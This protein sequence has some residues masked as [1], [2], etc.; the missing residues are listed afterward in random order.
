MF[1]V[2]VLPTEINATYRPDH[3]QV[4]TRGLQP[5]AAGCSVIWPRGSTQPIS[6]RS[7]PPESS[8]Y[9]TAGLLQT[10]NSCGWRL[11]GGFSAW[12]AWFMVATT[13]HSPTGSETRCTEFRCSRAATARPAV[14]RRPSGAAA[15]CPVGYLRGGGAARIA[16]VTLADRARPGGAL[17]RRGCRRACRSHDGRMAMPS[18][19]RAGAG[20]PGYAGPPAEPARVLGSDTFSDGVSIAAP[21]FRRPRRLPESRLVGTDRR[22]RCRPRWPGGRCHRR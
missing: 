14:A 11:S 4:I 13:T 8:L 18:P 17:Q 1:V 15:E 2:S 21:P 19:T 6:P 20:H 22:K 3:Q 5:K 16:G 10:A 12:R 7:P 9:R